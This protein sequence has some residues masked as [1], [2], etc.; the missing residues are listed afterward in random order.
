MMMTVVR[1]KVLVHQ[2]ITWGHNIG[3]QGTCHRN[4][5]GISS[6]V[7]IAISPTAYMV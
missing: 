5:T 7:N 2:G 3:G 1:V 4:D 6:S